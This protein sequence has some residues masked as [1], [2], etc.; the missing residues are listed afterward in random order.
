MFA[1]VPSRTVVAAPGPSSSSATIVFHLGIEP[2]TGAEDS[3]CAR[4]GKE[5]NDSG[6]AQKGKERNQPFRSREFS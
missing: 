1:S 6:C 5:R 2:R 4:K 3:G